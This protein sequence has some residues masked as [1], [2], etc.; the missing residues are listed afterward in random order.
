VTDPIGSMMV[1]TLTVQTY[2][3][4]GISANDYAAPVSVPCYAEQEL[5]Q[6]TASTGKIVASNYH[7]FTR[8][9][10]GDKFPPKSLVAVN[11]YNGE[12]LT[13]SKRE[14]G[15]TFTILEHCEVHLT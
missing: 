2:L 10:D 11:G 9:A 14:A 1:H 13:Q 5:H 8:L 3:G 6:V 7:V 15:A 4:Q 12:V